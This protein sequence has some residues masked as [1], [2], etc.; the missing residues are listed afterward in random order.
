LHRYAE[1]YRCDARRF[2]GASQAFR[3]RIVGE[4]VTLEIGKCIACGI[5]QQITA[6]TPGAAGLATMNRSDAIR[7]AP[8]PGITLDDALGSAAKRCADSCP[9]GAI[10][11]R[12]S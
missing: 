3:G 11:L 7:I 9:T 6:A 12:P 5:C 4:R 10:V 2:A 1:A 8:P